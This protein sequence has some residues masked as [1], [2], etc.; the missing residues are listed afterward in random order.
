VSYHHQDRIHDSL[1]KDPPDKR[2]I[3]PK[4]ATTAIVTSMPR[5][6]SL[7][8]RYAWREV[9]QKL[10]GMCLRSGVA[11]NASHTMTRTAQQIPPTQAFAQLHGPGIA[12]PA[13]IAWQVTGGHHHLAAATDR[14]GSGLTLPNVEISADQVLATHR[15]LKI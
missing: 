7:H 5:L 2:A 14:I 4:P 3:E 8:H 10:S 11:V 6:G 1:E 15:P 13:R 9:A 12:R